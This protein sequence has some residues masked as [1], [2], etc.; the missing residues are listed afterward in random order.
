[1]NGAPEV[2]RLARL[3]QRK[4]VGAGSSQAEVERQ[5]A[6]RSGYLSQILRGAIDLKV[7]QFFAIVRVIGVSPWA[8]F[9]ELYGR[10]DLPPHPSIG[11]RR[12]DA[13]LRAFVEDVVRDLTQGQDL[14]VATSRQTLSEGRSPVPRVA[15]LLRRTIAGSGHSQKAAEKALGWGAG[16][17]SQILAGKVR[18]KFKH[19]FAILG[20]IGVAPGDF[21]AELRAAT[22]PLPEIEASSGPPPSLPLSE[23]ELFARVE[24]M[25]LQILNRERRHV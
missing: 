19:L 1:M 23:D 24:T 20:A 2:A 18:L 21:F 16:Y 22:G 14:P 12:T 8:F 10:R 13:E 15:E 6:W 5:L 25:V 11:E 17:I 3:L 4:I 7:D 9:A